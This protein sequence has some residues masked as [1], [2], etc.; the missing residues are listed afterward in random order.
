[1]KLYSVTIAA[2]SDDADGIAQSQSAAGAE[3]LTLNGALVS[4]GTATMGAAQIITITSAADDSGVV[5]TITGTDADGVAQTEEVTG[6]NASTATSAKYF[7]TVTQVATDG[8]T[9]G[10]VTVGPVASDGAVSAT[11]EC[12]LNEHGD[13]YKYLLSTN[14][15]GSTTFEVETC[16]E[17]YSSGISSSGTW[18]ADTTHTGK[19]ADFQSLAVVPAQCV[20][21]K[22]SSYTSGTATLR[23]LERG[24]RN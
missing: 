17:D 21:L 2:L 8:A 1:M 13:D 11:L 20:R 6:A 18:I 9:T 16:V 22:L 4:A 14:I 5:F 3:D 10:N 23:V 7:K 15:S 12:N 19:T 24:D